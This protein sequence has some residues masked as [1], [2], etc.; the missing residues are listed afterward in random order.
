MEVL[1]RWDTWRN[2]VNH[3]M[4]ALGIFWVTTGLLLSRGH[5]IL[6]LPLRSHLDICSKDAYW[7]EG[8][9]VL[10]GSTQAKP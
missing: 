9:L 4:K 8:H 1:G 5:A 2:V 10:S 3:W 6:V 7:A